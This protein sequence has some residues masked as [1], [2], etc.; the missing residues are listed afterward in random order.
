MRIRFAGG[1]TLAPG[2][3]RCTMRPLVE[4]DATPAST[5]GAISGVA[6]TPTASLPTAWRR[7][8]T[9]NLAALGDPGFRGRARRRSRRCL[10]R[11][12]ER[13]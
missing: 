5:P 8:S 13:R 12:P 7:V 6:L 1:S 10:H 4:A 2:S 3:A 9:A 11:D